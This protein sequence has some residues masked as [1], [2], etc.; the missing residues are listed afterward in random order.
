[1]G[2]DL[3]ADFLYSIVISV[4]LMTFQARDIRNTSKKLAGATLGSV[5][6]TIFLHE[7]YASIDERYSQARKL[8][9]IW[10]VTTVN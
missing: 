9:C 7:A 4:D 5:L 6:A 1:M 10:C 3:A 2:F 8:D